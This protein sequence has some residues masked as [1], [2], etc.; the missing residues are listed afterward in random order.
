MKRVVFVVMALALAACDQRVQSLSEYETQKSE[1]MSLP[2]AKTG[3]YSEAALSEML[4]GLSGAE[5]KKAMERA[6][7]L[8]FTSNQKLRDPRRAIDELEKL[9]AMAP[10]FAPAYRVGGY[11]YFLLQDL[12]SAV[13]NYQKAID[14]DPNYGDA[15][16][17]LASLFVMARQDPAMTKRILDKALS[18]GVKD[19]MQLGAQLEMAAANPE[20]PSEMPAGHPPM[21]SAASGAPPTPA[22]DVPTD[23]EAIPLKLTGIGSAQE[24]E[25][26]SAKLSDPSLKKSLD[27]AFRYTFTPKTQFRDKAA[28]KAEYEKVIAAD[29]S[30]A[31][32]YRGLAYVLFDSGQAEESF[33]NYQKA[34]AID[35]DYGEVHYAIAFIQAGSQHAEGLEH[36]KRAMALGVPD[37]RKLGE[38]FY[39]EANR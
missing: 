39:T 24:L 29:P 38:R 21:G 35:P 19:T 33:T 5:E 12:D 2:L 13:E 1:V 26:V 15:Y 20:S 10:K 34:L 6:Y 31:A 28:A 7:R 32:A 3:P 30:C 17:A 36:F 11:A 37:E 23:G 8:T 4:A 25:R 27:K 9:E 22:A 16:Y 18:L 14:A